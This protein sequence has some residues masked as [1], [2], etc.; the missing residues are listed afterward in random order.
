MTR[1][2]KAF[3]VMF[4]KQ[5]KKEESEMIGDEDLSSLNVASNLNCVNLSGKLHTQQ[6]IKEF[7]ECRKGNSLDIALNNSS[8]KAPRDAGKKEAE[9][10]M[11]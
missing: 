3:N 9:S 6:L 2:E 8:I 1:R 7:G 10:G 4:A 11:V 5:N